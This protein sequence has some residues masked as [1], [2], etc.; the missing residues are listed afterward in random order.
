MRQVGSKGRGHVLTVQRPQMMAVMQKKKKSKTI[1]LRGEAAGGEK[2][3]GGE[4]IVRGR[5]FLFLTDEET[6]KH[7]D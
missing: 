6:L 2:G 3:R 7:N 1:T 5:H 4:R